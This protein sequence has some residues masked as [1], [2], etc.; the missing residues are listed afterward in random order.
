[1][2]SLFLSISLARWYSTQCKKMAV[3]RSGKGLSPRTKSAGTLILN[4]TVCRTIRNKRLL[5]KP[6]CSRLWSQYK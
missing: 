4:F 3:F 1:I 2:S 5:I 6:L